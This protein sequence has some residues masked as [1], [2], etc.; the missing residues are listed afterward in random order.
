MFY[1]GAVSL[2]NPCSSWTYLCYRRQW[3]GWCSSETL[4]LWTWC[5]QSDSLQT[6]SPQ[7]SLTSSLC[8]WTYGD[9]MGHSN[10]NQQTKKTWI[11][12]LL[13]LQLGIRLDKMGSTVVNPLTTIDNDNGNF[14]YSMEA[15]LSILFMLNSP[16][17]LFK[18]C[19]NHRS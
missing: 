13:L 19:K 14:M 15:L 7:T 5:P 11:S 12:L 16:F 8:G 18:F 1:T 3:N 9:A 17:C 2:P 6:V 10:M 4:C